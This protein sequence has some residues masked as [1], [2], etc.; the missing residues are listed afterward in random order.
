[1]A[2]PYRLQIF[3][4][5]EVRDALKDIAHEERTS[6]QDLIS[7]WLLDKIHEYPQHEAVGATPVAAT[8]GR[9]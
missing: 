5:S 4:E 9:R 8:P 3:L 7:E 6:L 2:S 1:M